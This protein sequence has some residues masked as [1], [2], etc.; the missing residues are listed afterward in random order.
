MVGWELKSLVPAEVEFVA[1]QQLLHKHDAD[2][3]FDK[4]IKSWFTIADRNLF[5]GDANRRLRDILTSSFG[6]VSTALANDG[7]SIVILVSAIKRACR[8]FVGLPS[9]TP[10]RLRDQKTTSAASNGEANA[11][12]QPHPPLSGA[13]AL[14]ARLAIEPEPD[15]ER[16]PSL[17]SI[18][19]GLW[20]GWCRCVNVSRLD[21]FP[22]GFYARC[23]LHLPSRLWDA[24]LGMYTRR[25]LAEVGAL[26]G[27]GESSVLAVATIISD[28][29]HMLDRI[30][31]DS[32]CRVLLMPTAVLDVTTWL[33]R[34][35]QRG[36]VPEINQVVHGF[37]HPLL[38]QVAIDLGPQIS[39][40]VERRIGV[41]GP[42]QT[43]DEIAHAFRLTR[44]RIR[45]LTKRAISVLRVR[46]PEGKYL[47]DD[48][49]DLLR[50]SH[51][52]QEQVNLVRRVVDILF[53]LEYVKSESHTEIHDA[54]EKLGRQK[55]TPMAEN[56]IQSWL[57]SEFPLITPDIATAWIKDHAIIA[58]G[59]NGEALYFTKTPQDQL[60]YELHKSGVAMTLTD[61]S[62]IIGGDERNVRLL[63]E[64]DP[65]FV[66]DE[67]K[68][69]LAAENCSFVRAAGVWHV[70]VQQNR[71]TDSSRPESISLES[72]SQ[73]IC[74]GLLELGVSDATVWGV[75]RY[76]NKILGQMRYGELPSAVS[77][78][79][80][81][82]KLVLHSDGMIRGMRRRRLRW[83]DSDRIPPARGKLGWI[84]YVITKV[85]VP[86][87]LRELDGALRTYYQDYEWYVLSQLSV[88]DEEDGEHFCGARITSGYTKYLPAI[89][90]PCEWHLDVAKEN[91]SE[92][93]KLLIA[94]I[95]AAGTKGKYPKKVLEDVPWL[96]ELVDRHSFGKMK[97]S[98]ERPPREDA[99]NGATNDGDPQEE[100]VSGRTDGKTKPQNG[101]VKAV[102]RIEDLLSRLF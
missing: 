68:R 57:A 55:R 36:I 101:Q 71:A 19:E 4:A 17:D 52:A 44:E 28:L 93:I 31:A 58:P 80:L 102:E 29:A 33:S 13:E 34:V 82:S 30:P 95:I 21:R 73:L 50:G 14:L 85:G 67:Y 38:R 90:V 35:L 66:E 74:T 37:I 92:E 62:E 10:K 48:F 7:I 91:V 51:R 8:E 61:A 18:P 63:L 42:P 86:M 41:D 43:L 40:M 97:W 39:E 77:P 12:E 54:W 9:K 3:L 5:R 72:L 60:L 88:D 27:H 76:A 24:Q 100:A 89:I 64:R 78:F 98:D 49:Y 20:A 11:N 65:R 47:L 75:Q 81:A 1:A 22:L 32:H 70:R 79:I 15:V 53:E 56:E 2:A 23:L 84:G 87:T 96:V 99:E 25:S 45:Q 16:L 83:D 94:K 69:I 59:S 26:E 6:D 46:W